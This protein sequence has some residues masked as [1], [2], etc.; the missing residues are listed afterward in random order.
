MFILKTCWIFS[1]KSILH[2]QVLPLSIVF[3]CMISFNNLCLKYVGVAFY[4]IGRSLTTVFN[5]VCTLFS[6]PKMIWFC[7]VAIFFMKYIS[8]SLIRLQ[9][10]SGITCKFCT[11]SC[12]SR[13]NVFQSLCCQWKKINVIIQLIQ[14]LVVAGFVLLHFPDFVSINRCSPTQCYSRAPLWRPLCAV[15]SSSLAFL[16]EW[17]KKGWQVKIFLWKGTPVSSILTDI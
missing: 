11:S 3:A 7:C 13:I 6:R 14:L 16:W 2:L 15:W 5:V 17:I 9:S 8:I 12:S 10:D 4:Y 1:S